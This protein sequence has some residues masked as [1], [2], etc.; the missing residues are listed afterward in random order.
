MYATPHNS[1][2]FAGRISSDVK[3]ETYNGQNGTFEVAFFNMAVDRQIPAAQKGKTD[4]CDF[5][6]F[7]ASGPMVNLLKN[8]GQKGRAFN[9]TAHYYAY[10]T[11]NNG[12][13]QYRHVFEVD[14]IA[15]GVGD[16]KA[17]QDA[18]AQG[19]N[20]NANAGNNNA[21]NNNYQQAPAGYNNV[22]GNANAN[23]QPPQT[24]FDMFGQPGGEGAF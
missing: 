4:S 19:Q 8:Y 22:Q 21:G 1:C 3:V 7:K 2:T 18:T 12:Q 15:F 16:S 23:Q 6:P 17:L 20:G 11:E 5:V 24:P 14:N 10:T 13:K 9:I